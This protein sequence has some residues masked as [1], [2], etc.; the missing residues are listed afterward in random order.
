MTKKELF[1]FTGKCLMLDEH[2]GFRQ[3]IIAKIAADSIDW[4][5]FAAICSN[6]LILQVIYLKFQTHGI[7]EYLPD[8][9]SEYLK[10]IYDLNLSRNNQ[11]L[12]QLHEITNILNKSNIYPV[13]LKGTGNLLDELYT[14]IGERIIGDIDFLV[15]EKD[16]LLSAKLLEY[17]GYSIT[18]PFYGEIEN[19]KHYP[20]IAK[21]GLPAILEIHRLPVKEDH[22]SWFNPAIIDKE[23]T[24]ITTLKGCYVLSDHH[25][26]IL[27]FIHGQLDHE[28][29]LY[30][31]VSF[32]DLY[33]LYL[34]SKR[35]DLKQTITRIKSK[36]KA[37][38]YFVFAG[39]A[40]GLDET[41]Y[42]GSNF[43]AW[44]F[45][46]KHDLNLRSASFYYVYRSAIYISQR[47]FIGYM[48]QLIKSLYSKKVRQSVIHR[49]SNRQWYSD[50]FGSYLAFFAPGK[51]A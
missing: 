8:E 13:F 34:L 42:P 7:I 38:A 25:K 20:R 43:S 51:K 14:D 10:D 6:H 35:V 2:P 29:H 17:E 37:I 48:G 28:N 1:Y 11:I 18:I 30:G 15:P 9:F 31:I 47:I 23:K 16:Y 44:L 33:D 5:K 41:F 19:L 26:I 45:S 50:H 46:K 27:N 3:E 40:F 24:T 4:L 12:Q 32:R 39:K 36:Q 22:Q 49:L 21:P